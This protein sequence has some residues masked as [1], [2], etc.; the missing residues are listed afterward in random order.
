MAVSIRKRSG[1]GSGPSQTTNKTKS[2]LREKIVQMYDVLLRGEDPSLSS[3]GDTFWAE[4]FL[5]KP[6]I[7]HFESE[8]TKMN[9][10]QVMSARSNLNALF[11]KSLINLAEE[12]HIRVVYALQTLCGLVRSAFKKQASTASG[13]DLVNLLMG[14][15]MAEKRMAALINH[16]ND[17][18]MGEEPASLKDLCLKL[19]LIITTGLDN[20]SQ[21]ML[22]EL[23]MANSVFESLIHLLTHT[24][25]RAIH[26]HNAVLLLTLL[27][28]YRKYES[29]N[30]Y[31]V[32]LSILD[33]ELAL[34]G[35]GHVITTSLATY[36]QSYESSLSDQPNSGWLS[37][38]T[39]MVGNMFVS[40]EGH[41]RIEQLRACNA[42]LLALYEAVHLN[43]NFI[44]TLGNTRGLL[45]FAPRFHGNIFGKKHPRSQFGVCLPKVG[46]SGPAGGLGRKIGHK[47]PQWVAEKSNESLVRQPCLRPVTKFVIL[48]GCREGCRA[49]LPGKATG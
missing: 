4:F 48:R 33:E 11:E 14:F 44:A 6:K 39:S 28:Q 17:F 25:S 22:M 32:K 20:V 23:I 42:V 12:H 49:R 24:E 21:N 8:L 7:S 18:L 34:H 41:V 45:R 47:F 2:P 40:D 19:L 43:R 15:D 46:V 30:P 1:S 9:H 10:E 3:F 31:I 35:Y 29:N 27:V 26:G 16:V 13:V 37:S 36:N 5:L 38:I